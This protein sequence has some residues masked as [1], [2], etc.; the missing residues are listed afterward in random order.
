MSTHRTGQIKI[1]LIDD[2]TIVRLGLRMLIETGSGMEVVGDV[3]NGRDALSVLANKQVDVILLDLDLGEES[4]LELLPQLRAA[5]KD[6]RVIALT[7][8]ADVAIQRAVVMAGA[9]GLLHKSQTK[10]LLLRAIEKVHAGEVWLDRLT[11]ANLITELSGVGGSAPIDPEAAKIRSLTE[12]EHEVVKLIFEGC[13]NR[14]IAERLS[15]SETTVRHHLSSVF[16]KLEVGSRLELVVYAH[17][18]RLGLQHDAAQSARFTATR[19]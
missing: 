7:G 19:K 2:H 9:L 14:Q 5:Q 4:G 17:R 10:E 15:I 3:G 13:A 11:I 1:L 8:S 12:R 16:S 6:V 18:H